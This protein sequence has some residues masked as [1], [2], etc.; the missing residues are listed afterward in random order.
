[1]QK[2]EESAAESESEGKRRLRFE[3]KGG[4]VQLELLKRSSQLL[5]LVCLYR[6]HSCK[7]HRLD[8]L[9]SG[10]SLLAGVRA[11]MSDSIADLYLHSCLDAGNDI[12]YASAWNLIARMHLHLQHA[13]LICNIFLSSA[14]KLDLVARLYRSVDNLEICDDS[15]ERV[16]YRVKYKGLQRSIRISLRSWNPLHDSVKN[17]LYALSCLS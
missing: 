14:Y 2:S 5:V 1:M 17:F 3:N 13:D 6:I 4:I 8:F 11:H 9:K 16:E 15:S 12:A 7:D 10:D